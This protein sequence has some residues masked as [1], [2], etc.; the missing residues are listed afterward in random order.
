[1]FY[2]S[3]YLLCTAFVHDMY[4]LNSVFPFLP[5][6]QFFNSYMKPDINKTYVIGELRTDPR[7]FP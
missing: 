5:P 2:R 1:M 6:K 7:G 4:H 3:V